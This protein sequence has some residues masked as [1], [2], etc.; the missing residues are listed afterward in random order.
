V[1]QG[2]FVL[3]RVTGDPRLMAEHVRHVRT[4]VE[5]LFGVPGTSSESLSVGTPR[6]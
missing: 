2:A 3:S 1:L 6:E 5:L 4:H